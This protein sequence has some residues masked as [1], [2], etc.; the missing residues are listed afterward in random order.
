MPEIDPTRVFNNFSKKG[1]GCT[2]RFKDN[3]KFPRKFLVTKG[4]VD[5]HKFNNDNKV[6]CISP[7][8]NDTGVICP[9]CGEGEKPNK[10]FTFEI[11]YI[12]KVWYVNRIL[13]KD[14]LQFNEYHSSGKALA[15]LLC[16]F[17]RQ[18]YK[19]PLEPSAFAG[20]PTYPSHIIVSL[21]TCYDIFIEK[22]STY[23]KNILEEL[24]V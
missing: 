22:G 15:T 1:I 11:Y 21:Q 4:C 8:A 7:L 14:K 10:K 9:F 16:C 17:C 24:H 2:I 6:V 18:Q 5:I 13:I 19:H 23:I 20:Y 12:D 3:H